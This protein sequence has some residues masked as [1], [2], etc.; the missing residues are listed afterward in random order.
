MAETTNFLLIDGEEHDGD[1]LL[2]DG[3]EHDGDRVLLEFSETS[4]GD[5]AAL[6]RRRYRR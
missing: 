2:L 1:V 4:G 5:A 3:E 6:R